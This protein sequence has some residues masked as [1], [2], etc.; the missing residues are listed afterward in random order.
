MVQMGMNELDKQLLEDKIKKF[1][2]YIRLASRITKTPM[3]E[4]RFWDN[5]CPDRQ[6][7]EIAHI[8]LDIP[9]GRICVR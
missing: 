8:H 5:Y 2:Y 7:D 4:V 1:T 9:G 6:V 3:P